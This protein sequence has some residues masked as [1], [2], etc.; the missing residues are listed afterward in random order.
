MLGEVLAQ[1]VEAALPARP[2]LC[3]PLL[4]RTQRRRLDATRSNPPDLLG[5]D[6]AALLEDAE[7]LQHRRERDSERP[8]KLADRGR[9]AAQPLY[10]HPAARVPE[11]MEEEVDLGQRWLRIHLSIVDGVRWASA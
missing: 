8:R 10:D 7:V 4:G 1:T 3:D 6:G 9:S 5:T 11:R 2:P